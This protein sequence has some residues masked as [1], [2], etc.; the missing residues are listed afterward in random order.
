MIKALRDGQGQRRHRPGRRPAERRRGHQGEREPVHRRVARLRCLTILASRARTSSCRTSASPSA[1]AR[2]LEA[3]SLADQPGVDPRARRRERRGQVDPRE[4]HLRGDRSPDHGPD[5]ARRR[6]GSLP[7]PA[8]RRSLAGSCSSRRSC[9]IVPR[10]VGGRER[11]PRHRAA[12][13]RLPAPARAAP[14]LRRAWPRSAGFELDRRRR[15]RA[16]C[17]SPT[18]RRS[19]SCARCRRDAQL[20]VM[21]EPTAALSRPDVDAPARD[22][23]RGSRRPARRSCWSRISCARCSSW[24]TTVTILRDGR[25][26]AH[27]A[28]R[29][30]DRGDTAERDA[31]PVRSA[32]PSR[33]SSRRAGGRAGG[34]LGPRA[35]RARGERRLARGARRGDRRPRRPGRRGPHRTRPGGLPGASRVDGGNGQPSP[36]RRGRQ[37]RSPPAAGRPRSRALRAGVAMIPESRK[38]QGLLLAALGHG[39]R[40]P[41]QPRPAQPVRA[42]RPPGRA[43]RRCSE[44][45]DAGRRPRRRRRR[46][47]RARCPAATS[48]RCCSPGCCCASRGC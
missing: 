36:A 9:R 15:P 14:P 46:A 26:V 34:A 40:Q 1:A 37:P 10:A 44:M 39:E 24:P 33:P 43:Q 6:A 12:A 45:L 18:S 28:P 2:A 19:R 31:R 27:R 42:G 20:I 5:A 29:G 38:E 21:D 3:V 16:A 47:G 4:D 23:P 41:G 22:H 11:V 48:R 35:Q 25:I 30:A 17:G 13:G 7:L 8:R 32:R